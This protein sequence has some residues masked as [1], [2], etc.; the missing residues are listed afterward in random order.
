MFLLNQHL[1]RVLFDSGAD[2]SFISLSLASMLNI[3]SITVDTFYNIEMADGNLVSTNTV[4]KGCTLTLL[5]QPFEID[6]MPIKLGSF[7]VVI[8][9]DWLSKYRLNS[10]LTRKFHIPI[11]GETLNQSRYPSYRE[12]SMTRGTR[13]HFRSPRIQND[14]PED[15]PSTPKRESSKRMFLVNGYYG[16]EERG[17]SQPDSGKSL[18][19][20]V[21]TTIRQEVQHNTLKP[22]GQSERTIQTLKDMLRACVIDF[23]K[24]WDKHLPLV[25]FSYN[26]SYHASIKTAP[27][28]AL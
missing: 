17:I 9:M 23:G 7:D 4:I 1:V 25:E 20:A 21:G 19:N 14:F 5:N 3:P 16:G 27:F 18:Q 11:Y 26:N 24:G 12:E 2:R 10:L 13:R 28:E 6:L 22:A 8:G 15:L